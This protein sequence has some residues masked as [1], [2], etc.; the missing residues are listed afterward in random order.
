MV[1]LSKPYF[2]YRVVNS[3]LKEYDVGMV[4]ECIYSKL[5]F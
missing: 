4:R 2:I 3:N 1:R 5:M